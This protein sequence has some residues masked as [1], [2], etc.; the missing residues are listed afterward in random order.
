MDIT[1]LIELIET[2]QWCKPIATDVIKILLEKDVMNMTQEEFGDLFLNNEK[3]G[4]RVY[5]NFL[6]DGFF[7][8]DNQ[9]SRLFQKEI[10]DGEIHKINH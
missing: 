1:D 6:A 10:K 2:L 8:P 9:Q 7:Y 5:I 4:R 3:I